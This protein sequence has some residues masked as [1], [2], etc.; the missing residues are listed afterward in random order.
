MRLSEILYY[1]HYTVLSGFKSKEKSN[2]KEGIAVIHRDIKPQ[3]IIFMSKN[4][5]DFYLIDFG[6]AKIGYT[7]LQK[8]YNNCGTAQYKAP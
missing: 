2:D 5:D 7:K 6:V 8:A 3:N 4:A 1:L